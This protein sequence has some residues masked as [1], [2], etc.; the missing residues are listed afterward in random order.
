VVEDHHDTGVVKPG[1]R[2]DFI[3]KKLPRG[4]GLH[5]TGAE[6]LHGDRKIL[7]HMPTSPDLPHPAAGDGFLQLEWSKID[8]QL[9]EY[10]RS[11][12]VFPRRKLAKYGVGEL[13][14]GVDSTLTTGFGLRVAPTRKASWHLALNRPV[15][16][17]V[18]RI[19]SSPWSRLGVA[20]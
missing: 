5:L 3:A 16:C 14:T 4:L 13:R 7:I 19:I 15:T 8:R 9:D 6:N 17:A 12:V 11:D 1:H 20:G 18:W 10:A 2:L